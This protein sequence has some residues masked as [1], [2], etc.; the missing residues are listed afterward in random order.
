MFLARIVGTVTSTIKHDAYNGTK[1]MLVQPISPQGEDNGDSLLAV[2]TV[3]AGIGERVLV[4][5]L[6]AAAAQVLKVDKPP[7]RTVIAGIVDDVH[8]SA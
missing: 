1:L 6:G 7:I 5:R 4:L 2:D 3:G 8:V